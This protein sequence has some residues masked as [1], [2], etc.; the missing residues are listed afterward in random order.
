MLT[1]A[2]LSLAGVPRAARADMV[3]PQPGYRL[4]RY[5][6]EVEG[7]NDSPGTL[8][9]T[10]PTDCSLEGAGEWLDPSESRRTAGFLNYEVLAPARRAYLGLHCRQ[11]LSSIHALSGSRFTRVQRRAPPGESPPLGYERDEAYTTLEQLDTCADQ[12]SCEA[13]LRPPRGQKLAYRFRPVSTAYEGSLLTAA[14]DVLAVRRRPAGGF[15]VQ[16]L[17]ITYTYESGASE[18]LPYGPDGVRP[19]PTLDVSKRRRPRPDEPLVMRPSRREPEPVVEPPA[20]DS[21]RLAGY[22]AGTAAM[23]LAGVVAIAVRSRGESQA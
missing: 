7:A 20:D 15:E 9:V 17:R 5:S 8:F 19:E 11:G 14:H 23:M 22:L 6:Y 1:A 18:T 2:G 10:Y 13:L 3:A 16:S 12:A 4:V 21:R